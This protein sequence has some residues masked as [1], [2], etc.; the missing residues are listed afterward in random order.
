MPLNTDQTDIFNGLTEVPLNT[1]QTDIFNG[2]TEVPLNI[3]QTD[4]FNGL[5]EIIIIVITSLL[6]VYNVHV[7]NSS[8]VIITLHDVLIG[9]RQQCIFSLFMYY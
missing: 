4:I 3:D 5:T 8:K 6:H 2:L 7:L 1:D 9:I